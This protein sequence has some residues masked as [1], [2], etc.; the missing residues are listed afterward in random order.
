MAVIKP[1]KEKK[2]TNLIYISERKVPGSEIEFWPQEPKAG[3]TDSSPKTNR[4]F[5]LHLSK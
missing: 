3:E 2:E 5:L 4:I 1:T